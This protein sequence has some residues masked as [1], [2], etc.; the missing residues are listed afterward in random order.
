M[1]KLSK[2][3]VHKVRR[4]AS[5]LTHK[6]LLAAGLSSDSQKMR[7]KWLERSLR[8]TYRLGKPVPGRLNVTIIARDGQT[9]PNSSLFIRLI[10]PLSDP[11]LHG[12]LNLTLKSGDESLVGPA[13]IYIIQRMAFDSPEQAGSFIK[14]ARQTGSKIILDTDDAF[15][16]IDPEHPEYDDHRE[17]LEAFDYTVKHADELWVSTQKLQK[18]FQKQTKAPVVLVPNSLDRRLWR[19]VVKHARG[20]LR[21]LYMGTVSHDA[22]FAT[23]YPVLKSLAEQQPGSFSL[24]LIGAVQ[25]V[26]DDRWIERLYAPR[27]GTLYPRFVP[28]LVKQ[29]SYDIGL[30]PLVDNDFN[31]GKSDIKCLDY[32]AGGSLPM[33]SDSEAYANP[34]LSDFIIRLKTASAWK[35][36]LAGILDDVEK[37]RRQK[38]KI[39]SQGQAYVWSQRNSERTAEKL[40]VRLEAL[41]QSDKR[42]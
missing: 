15:H 25:D 11:S 9:L 34:E 30:S 4:G 42:R 5:V 1:T 36:K 29:G 16:S 12:K 2:R 27:G 23:I 10:S 3:V 33:V 6:P 7:H 18:Y 19:P 26:P 38:S 35:K 28:W 40:W 20:P 31:R 14:S 39:V 24:T 32:L 13:D 22:D 8:S 21:L 37:F 41:A 17:W